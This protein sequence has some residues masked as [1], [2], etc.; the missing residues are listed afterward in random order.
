MGTEGE[1]GWGAFIRQL[2]QEIVRAWIHARSTCS[3]VSLGLTAIGLGTLAW[4][5]WIDAA[6]ALIYLIGGTNLPSLGP[7]AWL[8]YGL[9]A[10]VTIVGVAMAV[11]CALSDRPKTVLM[12]E[13][14]SDSWVGA[15][16]EELR[17]QTDPQAW[18]EV[19][20]VLH[21]VG[22]HDVSLLSFEV[23]RYLDGIRCLNR[24]ARLTI[25]GDPVKFG[26]NLISLD[27]PLVLPKNSKARILYHRDFRAPWPDIAFHCQKLEEDGDIEVKF[28]YCS[29]NKTKIRKKI[30][31]FRHLNSQFRPIKGIREP[32]ILTQKEIFNARCRGWITRKDA[33]FALEIKPEDRYR[34]IRQAK[35]TVLSIHDAGRLGMILQSIRQGEHQQLHKFNIRAIICKFAERIRS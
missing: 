30:E 17:R 29:L 25:D 7:P 8:Q 28:T 6:V 16:S 11:R 24:F 18:F 26:S 34:A 20:S 9:P 1:Q 32:P 2:L 10:T 27:P 21:V 22:A 14:P 5:S 23:S 33:V 4:P 3:R 31:F 35:Q 15:D 19:S 12:M 13:T